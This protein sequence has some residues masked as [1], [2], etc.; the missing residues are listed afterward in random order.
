MTS[1]FIIRQCS[2][3]C[4]ANPD[5]VGYLFIGSVISAEIQH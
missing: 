4:P 3:T 1:S 2:I 5:F